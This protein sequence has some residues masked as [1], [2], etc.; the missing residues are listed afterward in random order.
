MKKI[1]AILDVRDEEEKEFVTEPIILDNDIQACMAYAQYLDQIKASR[2]SIIR[3]LRLYQIGC[4][5]NDNPKK[6]I[7]SLD[8]IK[9]IP[10]NLNPM[11]EE[12]ENE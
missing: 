12:E 1:Y 2:L 4:Y 11:E 7:F 3:D 8:T 6:P 10:I 5:Y 9:E